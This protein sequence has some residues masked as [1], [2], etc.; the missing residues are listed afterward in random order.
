MPR[1]ANSSESAVCP[2][3]P[4]RT[5]EPIGPDPSIFGPPT[6]T[7]AETLGDDPADPVGDPPDWM[8]PPASDAEPGDMWSSEEVIYY[9]APDKLHAIPGHFDVSQDG[10]ARYSVPIVLP[11]NRVDFV[12]KLSLDYNSSGENDVAGMGWRIAGLSS[13]SRC[14]RTIADHDV[15]RAVQLSADD[16]LCLDGRPLVAVSG[17]DGEE[18]YRTLP[19]SDQRIRITD[20]DMSEPEGPRIFEVRTRDDR[21]L[22]FGGHHHATVSHEGVHHQWLLQ[23]VEDRFGNRIEYRYETD[24]THN[25]VYPKWIL[26]GAFADEL[27]HDKAV[28]FV[29]EYAAPATNQPVIGP[30]AIAPPDSRFDAQDH[31]RFGE[32]W[33]MRRRLQSIAVKIDDSTI[34]SYDFTYDVSPSTGRSILTKIDECAEGSIRRCK[35][36]TRFEYASGGVGLSSATPTANA[37]VPSNAGALL[38]LDLNGDGRDDTAYPKNDGRWHIALAPDFVDQVTDVAATT[39]DRA[40]PLDYDNDGN[41]DLLLLDGAKNWI[42]LRS[43]GVSL[44]RVDTGAEK[45]DRA[46][47]PTSVGS[48]LYPILTAGTVVLDMNGDG[49]PDLLHQRLPIDPACDAA[50]TECPPHP[51]L[52]NAEKQHLCTAS[53]YFYENTGSGFAAPVAVPELSNLALYRTQH[54]VDFEGDGAQDLLIDRCRPVRISGTNLHPDDG[55]HIPSYCSVPAGVDSYDV[56]QLAA[57]R[58][59]TGPDFEIKAVGLNIDAADAMIRVVQSNHDGISDLLIVPDAMSASRPRLMVGTGMGYVLA[60]HAVTSAGPGTSSTFKLNAER[61]RF[62]HFLD[63]NGDGLT[64]IMVPVA[65]PMADPPEPTFSNEIGLVATPEDFVEFVVLTARQDTLGYHVQTTGHPFLGSKL[66]RN[67]RPRVVDVNGDGADDILIPTT[68]QVMLHETALGRGRVDSLV[69]IRP[70]QFDLEASV[71]EPPI[72]VRYGWLSPALT[73]SPIIEGGLDDDAIYF[74]SD[75]TCSYPCA[76]LTRPRPAVAEVNERYQ[77]A[78]GT[79][80]SKYRYEDAFVDNHG[81]GWLGFR[82]MLR[83]ETLSSAPTDVVPGLANHRYGEIWTRVI[84]EPTVF[85]ATFRTYPR[86]GVIASRIVFGTDACGGNPLLPEGRW[87]SVFTSQWL[88][89]SR[90]DE[91]TYAH[92]ER[93]SAVHEFECLQESYQALGVD[94]DTPLEDLLISA[95]PVR[96]KTSMVEQFDTFG[97]SLA[98]VL[99]AEATG[100]DSAA[101]T[102]RIVST[103]ENDITRWLIGRLRSQTITDSNAVGST[104]R[105]SHRTYD[106]V[107]GSVT[108]ATSGTTLQT[109]GTTP[110][111]REAN[112]TYDRFGNVVEVEQFDGAHRRVRFRQI[113]FDADGVFP[114]AFTNGAGHTFFTR[115]EPRFGAL[116]QALDPNGISEWSFYDSMGYLRLSLNSNEEWSNAWWTRQPSSAPFFATSVVQHQN[117]HTAQVVAETVNPQGLVTNRHEIGLRGTVFEQQ[118]QYTDTSLIRQ[119]SR[120]FR[121]GQTPQWTTYA[122]DRRSRP[123][124]IVDASGATSNYRRAG[125]RTWMTNGNHET[126]SQIVDG[127]DRVVSVHDALGNPAEY[128]YGPFDTLVRI[129]S[130]DQ[131][132]EQTFDTYGRRTSILDPNAGRKTFEVDDF[133]RLVEETDARGQ[134]TTF[135]YDEIGRRTHEYGPDGHREWVYDQSAHG[136]GRLSEDVSSEGLTRQFEYN[137]DSRLSSITYLVDS[138]SG[139][140]DSFEATFDYNARG[141]LQ[142]YRYPKTA[143]SPSLALRYRYDDHGHLTV[144]ED[145]ATSAVL[146]TWK[147]NGPE[148][149]IEE[150]ELG[151]GVMTKYLHSV[152]TGLPSR[153]TS[154]RPA[155]PA[156]QDLAYGWDNNRNLSQQTDWRQGITESFQYDALDRLI[157]WSSEYLT[158]SYTYA[159][160]GNLQSKPGLPTLNYDAHH[161]P[162]AVRETPDF[163]YEYDGV[164]NQTLRPEPGSDGPAAVTYNAFNKPKTIELQDG[165][166]RFDYDSDRLRFR[167]TTPS[168]ETLYLDGVLERVTSPSGALQ[169]RMLVTAPSGPVAMVQF[170]QAPGGHNPTRKLVYL[171]TDVRGSLDVVTTETGQIEERRSYTPFGERRNVDWRQTGPFFMRLGEYMVGFTGHEDERQYGWVNMNGR[172]YDAKLGRFLN[173]DPIVGRPFNPQNFNR[174]SYV[175][176][177][178]MTLIDPTGYDAA[179]TAPD[180]ENLIVKGRGI[181]NGINLGS[182]PWT[183]GLTPSFAPLS[184]SLFVSETQRTY[185]VTVE[186]LGTDT[187]ELPPLTA[188]SQAPAGF[189]A[190]AGGGSG[191]SAG[192]PGAW[193]PQGAASVALTV[194]EIGAGFTPLGVVVDV[195]DIARAV[196]SGDPVAIGISIVGLVPVFGK[197]LKIAYKVTKRA[198]KAAKNAGRSLARKSASTIAKCRGPQCDVCFVAG[199]LVL[200]ASGPLSIE[201]IVAGDRVQTY[202]GGTTEWAEKDWRRVHLTVPD[203]RDADHLYQVVRLMTVTDLRQHQVAKAGDT[204]SLSMPELGLRGVGTITLIET[205]DVVADGPGRVVMATVSHLNKDVYELSFVDGAEALRGTGRHPLYSLD[206]DDWVRIRD[207]QVGERLQTAEGAVSV[208]ALEKVRGAHRVYNLEVEGDHEYLVGEAGV[209]AHNAGCGGDEIADALGP[210]GGRRP[211]DHQDIVQERLDRRNARRDARGRAQAG[212]NPSG[213]GFRDHASAN[214]GPEGVRPSRSGGRNRERNI[215]IDEEHSM[216]AKGTGGRGPGRR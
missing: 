89:Q 156:F 80:V 43:T 27:T 160:N 71:V 184:F 76:R 14:G 202:E 128:E 42:V 159:P 120:R 186:Y 3:L 13:I 171:H 54:V 77:P 174:Y 214:K 168:D 106:E 157:G 95:T 119:V 179:P 5:F 9:D 138:G 57:P 126:S 63:Y 185:S 68:N 195:I 7:P 134:S 74:R 38:T 152:T 129:Q 127:R 49:A 103:F 21:V 85:D 155:Q 189:G 59:I 52:R 199:T 180:I 18:E 110:S 104:A 79:L 192:P 88:T 78:G 148:N 32:R 73:P 172:L 61:L 31:Y 55:P 23:Q 208:E 87:A 201:R 50:A 178:P 15:R 40:L 213:E 26:Y 82:T 96:R 183:H 62:S 145:S 67:K 34:R 211:P 133:G 131:T 92:L 6:F 24:A 123:Q 136:I 12:P 29:Y 22:T 37:I 176:N 158:K 75:H 125:M 41:D 28:E 93:A 105:I 132:I 107:T 143:N 35:R 109:V 215:G 100:V 81:R 102:T 25:F 162:H 194:I 58:T 116:V 97:N 70:G 142:T 48:W 163:T 44:E 4:Y 51:F 47:E 113:A 140:P 46:F 147:T 203:E 149:Q 1:G 210:R 205:G 170:D 191:G 141:E 130:F 182:Q 206:R 56:L 19:D 200:G 117:N 69:A 212:Q 197:G 2:A 86:A 164:G 135:C 153:I 190:S 99:E 111:Y 91:A 90:Y 20:G 151:N 101:H 64:D 198:A 16:A 154:H 216:K 17:P 187:I 124:Q 53:W 115:Y 166:H 72:S 108:Q 165:Q 167:K 144:I 150:V 45:L 10:S 137:E 146:W 209:R 36:P 193:T 207:L 175:L 177:N 8:T 169:Y 173:A 94:M 84:A 121:S 122:Y 60:G 114:H 83:Q 30:N 139:A 196:H 181:S 33:K 65:D 118:W 188:P 204:L 11:P 66:L 161:Q 39:A 98:T 112:F